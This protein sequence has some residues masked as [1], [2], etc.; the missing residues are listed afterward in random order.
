MK[1]ITS[2][3]Q[4]L[5]RALAENTISPSTAKAA[6]EYA[7]LCREAEGRLEKVAQMLAAGGD[8]QALQAAEQEP[9]LLDLVA[10]LSFG[11]E[12]AWQAFCETHQLPVATRLDASTVASLDALYA[13]GINANHPLYKDFRSAVLSR[14]DTKALQ[15]IRTILKLNPTDDN[16]KSE[17]KRLQNKQFQE[18]LTDLRSALKTDDE[19]LIA[20]LTESLA[21]TG[22]P[23]ALARN[24]DYQ[25]GESI[26]KSLRRRQA[27][28]QLPL[29]LRSMEEQHAEFDWQAVGQGL[30]ELDQLCTQHSL[31]LVE[32][33]FAGRVSVLRDYHSKERGAADK[34]RAF[35]RSLGGFLA[36]VSEVETR[37]LSG[38]AFPLKEVEGHDDEFVRRWKELEE[39][40]LPVPNQS[41]QR[42]RTTGQELRSRLERLQKAKRMRAWS[43][44][45]AACLVMSAL[46]AVG[47][48]AWKANALA[49]DLSSWRES[50]EC[51]SVEGLIRRLR[52]EEALLLRWPFLQSQVESSEAWTV[53]ARKLEKQ[54]GDELTA[55]E[56]LLK[57][58]FTPAKASHL[59]QR[60]E[61]IATV[62]KQLAADLSAAPKNR[63]TSLRTQSELKFA[64]LRDALAGGADSAVT[65]LE[66]QAREALSHERASSQVQ[67]DLELILK[68][69][70]PL[71][72]LVKPGLDALRL[73]ADL[74]SRLLALRQRVDAFH[75]DLN[76]LAK[77]RGN[78]AAATSLQAYRN[79]LV[80]W[81]SLAFVEAA[82]ALKAL[83]AIPKEEQ[84]LA[85]VLTDGDTSLLQAVLDDVTGPYMMP[86]DKP[87]DTELGV[88]LELLDDPHL[89]DLWQQTLT[90]YGRPGTR[91]IIWSMGQPVR[92][93][94][95][96]GLVRWHGK[97]YDPNLTTSVLFAERDYRKLTTNNGQLGHDISSPAL[98][99][100]S[101]LMKALPLK[102]MTDRDGL[103]YRKS[104]LELFG[105]V[106]NHPAQASLAKAYVTL[107]LEDFA[108]TRS[109]A[110]GMHFCPRLKADLRNLHSILG[111]TVLESDDHLSASRQAEFGVKLTAHFEALKGRDYL[112]EAA[113]RRGI[114]LEA[115]RGGMHYGGYVEVD[116]TLV[117]TQAARNTGELWVINQQ[118]GKP[119]VVRSPWTESGQDSG[120]AA[121]QA[122][123]AMRLSPV[124]YMKIDRAKLLARYNASLNSAQSSPVEAT[125]EATFFSAP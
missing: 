81:Q 113:A 92:S 38:S 56:S 35:D 75:R 19:E 124:F 5:R 37:L 105:S 87:T 102:A 29:L 47:W 36:F 15:I 6:E 26:R 80:G 116:Q 109:E 24:S 44:A 10:A 59:Q 123:Q 114:L 91:T 17:L 61:D 12:K 96:G 77:V 62:V 46:A 107:R 85:D 101:E 22:D 122:K 74:E 63:L 93:E 30:E 50:G 104:V 95:G 49:R 68:K 2:L 83:N 108:N 9:P 115:A 65:R 69:L 33:D 4:S 52:E 110:W 14:N 121:I 118:T 64:D 16:A 98:T 103:R 40:H 99:A 94:V 27:R 97:F 23:E 86:G 76:D 112:K 13:R 70:A 8:Y 57:E 25:E 66:Q 82:P 100:T 43:A 42:L 90:D 45:T 39:F 31:D 3:T 125:T 84:I 78:T 89:N 48:H 79:A 7:L 1:K 18:Q 28:E 117:L 119:F 71:E 58:D 60:L 32:L 41:L 72:S 67:A 54:A 21:T 55:L 106:V 111:D 34:R 88:M 53:Q 73:P 51:E 11:G 120:L 20:N